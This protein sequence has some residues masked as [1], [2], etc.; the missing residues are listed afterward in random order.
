[1]ALIKEYFELTKKYQ[2]EYGVNTIL[3][4]Q[5]GAFFEV[6]GLAGVENK[7]ESQIY[8]FAQI[9]DLNIGDKK[10]VRIDNDFEFRKIDIEQLKKEYL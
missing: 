7:D 1:M 10:T 9:C 6:Y 4:M 3:L 8:E 2:D 5:V